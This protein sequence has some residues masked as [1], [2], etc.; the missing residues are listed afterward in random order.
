M[1]VEFVCPELK[2]TQSTNKRKLK[3]KIKTKKMC[4]NFTD[5]MSCLKIETI[6]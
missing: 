5:A 2:V 4:E 3:L 1:A 6:A